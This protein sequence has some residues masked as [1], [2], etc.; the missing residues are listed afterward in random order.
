[1][2]VMRVL[3]WPPSNA[4]LVE[5]Q[6]LWG[7]HGSLLLVEVWDTMPLVAFC[8]WVKGQGIPGLDLSLPNGGTL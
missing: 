7:L 5:G 3:T 1:M 4:V 2:E 8:P 6:Q